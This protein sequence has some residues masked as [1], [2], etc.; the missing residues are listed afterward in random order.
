MHSLPT[1]S[2]LDTDT[3]NLTQ[4]LQIWHMLVYQSKFKFY[5]NSCINRKFKKLLTFR[6]NLDINNGSSITVTSLLHSCSPKQR[7]NHRSTTL[8]STGPTFSSQKREE[9]IDALKLTSPVLIGEL[10]QNLFYSGTHNYTWNMII[11]KCNT[12]HPTS[13]NI[14]HTHS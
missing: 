13:F 6:I 9:N 8:V 5:I 10:Q 12:V 3:Y 14:H 2:F 7:T 11:C 4:G 1:H